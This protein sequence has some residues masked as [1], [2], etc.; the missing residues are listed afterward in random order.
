MIKTLIGKIAIAAILA[1]G[2]MTIAPGGDAIAYS[3][4]YEM[5][6]AR[7]EKTIEHYGDPIKPIVEQAIKNNENNPQSKDTAE[8]TYKRKSLL[9][10]LLPEQIGDSFS[11]EDLLEMTGTDDPNKD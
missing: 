8:N 10:P 1:V 2:L 3:V 9:N 5:D 7:V 4:D 6:K 11:K